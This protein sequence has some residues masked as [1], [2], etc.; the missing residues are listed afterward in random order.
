MGI[1]SLKA[2]ARSRASALAMFVCDCA[3]TIPAAWC[4]TIR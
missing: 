3:M 2:V 1:P 4:T